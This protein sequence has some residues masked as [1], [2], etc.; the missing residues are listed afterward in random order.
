M[1]SALRK[2]LID[3]DVS[4]RAY[5]WV[6]GDFDPV[7]FKRERRHGLQLLRYRGQRRRRAG[8]S[9]VFDHVDEW[10][11][12]RVPLERATFA[13]GMRWKYRRGEAKYAQS[14]MRVRFYGAGG[15]GGRGSNSWEFMTIAPPGG[16]MSIPVLGSS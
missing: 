12:P 6:S 7:A 8:E 5:L 2:V 10:S 16:V 1:D 4:M 14:E 13:P 9:T 15:S 3:A 11:T